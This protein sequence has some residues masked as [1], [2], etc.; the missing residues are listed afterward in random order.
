MVVHHVKPAGHVTRERPL[1]HVHQRQ[2]HTAEA[3][4]VE[5]TN[6]ATQLTLLKSA[7]LAVQ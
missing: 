5:P 2:M 3:V 1:A 6:G 4:L 7:Q